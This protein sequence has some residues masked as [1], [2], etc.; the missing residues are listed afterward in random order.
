MTGRNQ[1]L[2]PTLTASFRNRT[3][4]GVP[5]APAAYAS[6]PLVVIMGGGLVALG[7]SPEVIRALQT[8]YP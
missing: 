7:R 3:T 5:G 2:E 6:G 4:Q 1:R 8:G